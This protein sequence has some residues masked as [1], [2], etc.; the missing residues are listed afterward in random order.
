MPGLFLLDRIYRM[1][2]ILFVLPDGKKK[3][4]SAFG[5]IGAGGKRGG[6]WWMSYRFSGL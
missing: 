6:G 4:P 5:G 3:M 1:D 2:R